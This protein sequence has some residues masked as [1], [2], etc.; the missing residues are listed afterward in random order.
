MT[1]IAQMTKRNWRASGM[2]A[3]GH[4]FAPAFANAAASGAA[5]Y[6]VTRLPSRG[7]VFL[8]DGSNV[9]TQGI[10]AGAKATGTSVWRP[11]TG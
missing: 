11:P 10:V 7:Q 4:A 5:L 9:R 2:P 3:C 8:L 1:N 6:D